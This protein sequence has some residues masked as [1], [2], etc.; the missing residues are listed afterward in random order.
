[1]H[2]LVGGL[3]RRESAFEVPFF[4]L[5]VAAIEQL[6]GAFSILRA[7]RPRRRAVRA[8]RRKDQAKSRDP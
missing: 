2:E 4:R 8:R 6:T 7:L 3:I 5:L 1:M